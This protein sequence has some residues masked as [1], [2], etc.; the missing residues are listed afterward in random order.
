MTTK[1]PTPSIP[2]PSKVEKTWKTL[3]LI[4]AIAA[5]GFGAATYLTNFQSE[6]DAK[7]ESARVDRKIEGV[8]AE[9]EK[10][11]QELEEIRYVNVRIEVAQAQVLDE[12]RLA[13]ERSR[14]PR[15]RDERVAQEE[16]VAEI[17][18]RIEVRGDALE[19][20]YER[21]PVVPTD[22]P[23]HDPLTKLMKAGAL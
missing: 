6:A 3:T 2:P 13:R 10:H 9:V 12:L 14:T 7:A 15:G 17:E 18:R 16:Q 23:R 22:A 19:E 5:A 8:K 21:R 1:P 4:G 11:D 20:S